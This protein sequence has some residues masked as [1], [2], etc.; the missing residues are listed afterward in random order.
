MNDWKRILHKRRE[1]PKTILDLRSRNVENGQFLDFASVYLI[2]LISIRYQTLSISMLNFCRY[3]YIGLTQVVI[4]NYYK[5]QM[6][7][8]IVILLLSK[9]SGI[10]KNIMFGK[11]NSSSLV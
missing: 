1:A 11:F 4:V 5:Y 9:Q 8:A 7:L 3:R 10:D 2:M 6:F